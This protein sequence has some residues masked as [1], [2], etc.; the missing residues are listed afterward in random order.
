MALSQLKTPLENQVSNLADALSNLAGNAAFTGS[1]ID[2]L[3][4][5]TSNNGH[6]EVN[7]R[8]AFNEGIEFTNSPYNDGQAYIVPYKVF[9]QIYGIGTETIY[10]I[11]YDTSNKSTVGIFKNNTIVWTYTP[12]S[13]FSLV[14]DFTPV[15]STT[16]EITIS[17]SQLKL[18]ATNIIDVSG[19]NIDSR[20]IMP[21]N[22]ADLL[23]TKLRIRN[24]GPEVLTIIIENLDYEILK[25][26]R[27]DLEDYVFMEV[28]YNDGV[29]TTN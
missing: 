22:E 19:H 14:T 13:N 24:S 4:Y 25:A 1:Q 15:L 17:K 29:I 21:A 3:F 6:G 10:F 27:Q 20:L 9:I 2:L 16:N 11:W 23:N 12:V 18:G 5:T 28:F 26:P 7:K 8:V